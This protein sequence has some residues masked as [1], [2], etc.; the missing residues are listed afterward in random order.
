[1]MFFCR[2]HRDFNLIKPP[3]SLRLFLSI[4]LLPLGQPGFIIKLIS[5]DPCHDRTR[6]WF[7]FARSR[8]N[9]QL[10]QVNHRQMVVP[11]MRGCR[12]RVYLRNHSDRRRYGNTQS[13]VIAA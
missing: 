1:M 13:L 12:Y 3:Y 4:L 2:L 5:P 8:V 9:T 7:I 11:R 10:P 6:F